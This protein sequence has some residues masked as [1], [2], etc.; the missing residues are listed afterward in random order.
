M[1]TAHK[2]P[3]LCAP[4][5]K[6]MYLKKNLTQFAILFYCIQKLYFIFYYFKHT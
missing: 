3:T 2:P 6:Q 4:N 5:K 1:K